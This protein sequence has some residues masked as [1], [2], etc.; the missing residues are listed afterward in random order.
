MCG[1][2]DRKVGT[3]IKH[4][5]ETRGISADVFARRLCMSVSL[6]ECVEDGS[7]ALRLTDVFCCA[8]AL[9]CDAKEL[10]GEL[11]KAVRSQTR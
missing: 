2:N 10:M 4:M 7:Y 6:L 8:D 3:T 1:E 5:R 9:G 11:G